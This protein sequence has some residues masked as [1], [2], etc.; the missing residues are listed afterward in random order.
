MSETILQFGA[1]NFLRAFVDLFAEQANRQPETAVGRIV[2]VQSTGM[3][4]ADRLNQA[5]GRY[6]VAIQGFRDGKVVD[7]TEPVSS[8]SRAL[9]AGTQWDEVLGV[10]RSPE[11]R[12]IISNTTEAGFSLDER[13]REPGGVP[14][15]FPAKLLDVLTV[16]YRASQPPPVVIPCE[17]LEDNAAR[18]RGLVLEQAARWKLDPGCTE[19]IRNGCGWLN[20]LVDR[21]VPGPPKSHPLS[22]L[23]PLLLSAEPFALW[24]VE[25]GGPFRF[26]HPAVLVSTDIRP[27][28]LRKIRILSG[29]HTALV[30]QALPRGFTTVRQCM[31]DPAMLAW[32]E[33]LLFGEIVPVLEGRVEDP[34]GFARTTLDRFRNPFLEHAL[35]SIAL[36]QEAKLKT[37]LEPTLREY[38]ER[39]GKNPPLLSA[40]LDSPPVA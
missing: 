36:N 16:R 7:E 30:C 26:C 25:T 19:W 31:E 14:V 21:I 32:L 33:G 23:D 38:R 27:H 20:N 15:S 11:L 17:L 35:A 29:A 24:A 5:G 28:S 3:E 39:F 13:D 4:R 18:L 8:I 40:I 2:V 6:H 12:W 37:R 34:E 1:G 10:A 9:H 22:G